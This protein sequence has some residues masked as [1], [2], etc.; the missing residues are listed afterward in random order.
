MFRPKIN[1]GYSDLPSPFPVGPQLNREVVVSQN[2]A[3]SF[4]PVPILLS[5]PRKPHVKHD[6]S[7]HMIPEQQHEQIIY[8]HR[9]LLRIRPQHEQI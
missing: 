2:D 8:P 7:M 4:V 3:K 9:A 1:K 5:C 6:Y